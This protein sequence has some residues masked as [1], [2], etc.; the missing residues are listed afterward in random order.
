MLGARLHYAVPKL[1][2]RVAMLGRFYTDIYAG[3]KAWAVR[4]LAAVPPQL[5]PGAVERFL[6]RS[7]LELSADVVVSFDAFGVWYWWQ[8]RRARDAQA[9]GR[10]YAQAAQLFTRSIVRHGLPGADVLYGYNGAALELIEYAKGQDIPCVL[11]QTIAPQDVVRALLREEL[12]RWPG[13]EPGLCLGNADDMMGQ[14]E[15]AEWRLADLVIGASPFVIDSLL[16]HRVPEAKCRVVPYGISLE[17]FPPE[18]RQQSSP[19][20]QLRL[21]FVGGVGLRKGAPYLLEALR[22]LHSPHIQARFAGPVALSAA[23][24]Q[25]YQALATFLGPVSRTRMT[26]L[27]RWADLLVFPSICEGS[28]LVTYEALASGLPVIATPNTGAWARDGI[29][30]LIVPVRDVEAL[31]AALERFVRD[32]EFLRFC[33]HNAL[34][35]RGRLG[36]DAYQR[37]LVRI[38]REVAGRPV[39]GAEV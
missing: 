7:D 8:V 18:E 4:P 26:D 19:S 6:G 21:L 20:S 35:G 34:A 23:R 5:R 22:L 16:Q 17:R 9:V 12:E 27:Y 15:Q 13:W 11:E 1:L 38:V 32:R 30:G 24:L 37:R 2:H 14:R 29:E 36:L 25:P 3:N 39:S 33:S 10:V 31:A 28:A